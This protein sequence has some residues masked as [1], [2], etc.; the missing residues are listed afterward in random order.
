MPALPQQR[1]GWRFWRRELVLLAALP[2]LAA[3][4]GPKYDFGE[5]RPSL[6][7]DTT[8][9][10]LGPAAAARAEVA[11]SKFELTDDE[12]AL[13]DLGFPLIEPPYDRQKWDSI[14]YEYG[15]AGNYQPGSFDRTAY[16]AHLLSSDYRSP[17]S[18]YARLTDDIRNDITRMPAFFETASRV[19][20]VDAKRRKSLAFVS[21]LSP[22]ERANALQTQP[23]ECADPRLG[24]QLAVAAHRLLSL[25][26]GAA[27]GDD[28]VRRGRR[29][30]ADAQPP[31][32]A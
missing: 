8:H 21:Q 1:S 22:Y 14:L 30:R 7:S 31:Q 12:R 29:G 9:D 11:P 25:R 27:G 16:A 18:R 32:G 10:W 15:A 19:I 2:L 20:D 3:C 24:A 6:A 26:A 23:R 5:I 17:A 28:A 4:G 13:R